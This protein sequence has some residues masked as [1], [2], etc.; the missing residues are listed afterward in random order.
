MARLCG[1]QTPIVGLEGYGWQTRRVRC[2]QRTVRNRSRRAFAQ[3]EGVAAHKIRASG[4]RVVERVEEEGGAGRE[5]VLDVL[6][7]RVD[8]GARGVLCDKAVVVDGVDIPL[9]RNRVPETSACRV[10]ERDAP[11]GQAI[12]L[13]TTSRWAGRRGA[14]RVARTRPCRPGCALCH[15]DCITRSRSRQGCRLCGQD[16]RPG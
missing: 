16:L 9:F 8:L 4:V 10:L 15:H 5:Q 14:C 13:K 2:K 12:R 7:Q 6:L 11:A 3:A 1:A